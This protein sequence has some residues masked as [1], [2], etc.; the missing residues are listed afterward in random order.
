MNDPA[1]PLPPEAELRAA[2]LALG[3]LDGDERRDAQAERRSDPAFDRAV[4][5]WERFVAGSDGDMPRDGA[6]VPEHL[7]DRI[8]AS[9]G[10][11]V[12]ANDDAGPVA[13]A[14]IEDARTLDGGR[15]SRRAAWPL[16]A[17]AASVAALVFAGLW[18]ARDRDLAEK[19]ARIA[20]LSDEIADA[21]ADYR[22]AQV[23]G[24]DTPALLTALYDGSAGEM[25]VRVQT[26]NT[27]GLVPELWVIGPDGTPRSLG[28]STGSAT[29]VIPVTEAMQAD[30][31][32]GSSIAISLEPKADR[33]SDTPTAENI[34]GAAQLV[35]IT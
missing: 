20:A 19:D 7:W 8:A 21:D 12:A 5:E 32:A 6:D 10:M 4:G 14:H 34:L 17:M 16:A 18:I 25:T 33:P 31:A 23:N 28:Q 13:G 1:P 3:L 24:A 9:I 26:E 27:E 2:E 35:P 30:I 29:I 15:P 11:P 22:V